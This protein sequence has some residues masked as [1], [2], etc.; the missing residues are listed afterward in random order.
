MLVETTSPTTEAWTVTSGYDLVTGLGSVNIANLAISW[1]TVNTVATTTDLTLTVP[2]GTTHGAGEN[3]PVTITVTP[4]SGTATGD[5]SL[6]AKF[7]DGT[8][9]GLDQFT[10]SSGTVSGTT[11]SL[12]GGMNYQ[13]YAH[14][15]GDGTNAPSDSAAVT[16][17]VGKESSQTFIVVPTFDSSGNQLA[18]NATAVPYGSNYIIRTYVLRQ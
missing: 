7:S 10:L 4:K 3:V 8:T 13:V 6:I 17:S 5:A 9:Q 15:A 11:N 1:G 18:G 16:V 14:Y 12:P 2:T